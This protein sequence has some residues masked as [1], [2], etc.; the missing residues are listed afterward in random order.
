MI[1]LQQ[2][3]MSIYSFL[4]TGYDI[5][6]LLQLG[7]ALLTTLEVDVRSVVCRPS[8]SVESNTVRP[9]G[10]LSFGTDVEEGPVSSNKMVS[11]TSSLIS[12]INLTAEDIFCLLVVVGSISC[13]S[14]NDLIE[15]RGQIMIR[16]VALA[17]DR[18]E[19][20]DNSALAI[21]N[22]DVLVASALDNGKRNDLV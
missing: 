17:L 22:G 10:E 21:G 4:L 6:K 14:R 11:D 13:R 12:H 18:V 9:G 19:V 16:V 2:Y 3:G 1:L 8:N 20:G 5:I 15:T 7:S